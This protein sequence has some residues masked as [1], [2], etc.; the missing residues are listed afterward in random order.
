MILGGAIASNNVGRIGRVLDAHSLGLFVEP[1]RCKRQLPPCAHRRS[2]TG[3][4]TQSRRDRRTHGGT[5]AADCTVNYPGASVGKY[6]QTGAVSTPMTCSVWS[7]RLGQRHRVNSLSATAR[8]TSQKAEPRVLRGLATR[9]RTRLS[10]RSLATSSRWTIATGQ[11]LA[12]PPVPGTARVLAN[13]QIEAGKPHEFYRH[14]QRHSG[15][16]AS[17]PRQHTRCAISR[18]WSHRDLPAISPARSIKRA[19]SGGAATAWAAGEVFVDPTSSTSKRST[20]TL[21][22]DCEQ[23]DLVEPV[24]P[25]SNS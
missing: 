17:E 14:L 6:D 24:R 22:A 1:S 3:H 11:R 7:K 4:G 5:T 2:R 18:G 23:R 15:R 21:L 12:A 25:A 19:G 13:H 9:P 16:R 10:R 8:A 20:G